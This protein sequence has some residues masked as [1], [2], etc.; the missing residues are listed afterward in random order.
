MNENH[1][2]Y[3]NVEKYTFLFD[4]QELHLLLLMLCYVRVCVCLSFG[5]LLWLCTGRSKCTCMKSVEVTI[6]PCAAF[7]TIPFQEKTCEALVC[8][9]AFSNADCF[10]VSWLYRQWR[11]LVNRMSFNGSCSRWWYSARYLAPALPK[12]SMYWYVAFV[13]GE[14]LFYKVLCYFSR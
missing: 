3:W 8:S 7:R 2:R 11:S 14:Y 10:S 13:W 4:I 12:C 9:R 1:L 5:M 6:L